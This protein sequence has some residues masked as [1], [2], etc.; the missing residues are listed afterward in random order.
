MNKETKISTS[1]SLI[2]E[3]GTIKDFVVLFQ[4]FYAFRNMCFYIMGHIIH[5]VL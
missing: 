3:I 5:T 2:P 1:P 4:N